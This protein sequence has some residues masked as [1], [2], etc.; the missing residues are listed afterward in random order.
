[1]DSKQRTYRLYMQSFDLPIA[2]HIMVNIPERRGLNRGHL[3][4]IT[5]YPLL[6]K[7]LC[8]KNK[9]SLASIGVRNTLYF[10][11]SIFLKVTVISPELRNASSDTSDVAWIYVR[12]GPGTSLYG[13]Q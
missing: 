11:D 1:M 5:I 12:G 2:T 10:G 9:E 6:Q 3:L 7:G 13:D 8:R 4:F